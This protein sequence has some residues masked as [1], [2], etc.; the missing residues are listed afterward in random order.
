M[1]VLADQHYELRWWRDPASPNFRRFFDITDLAAVRV[2]V[3]G[4]FEAQ[5]RLLR[6]WVD[7]DVAAEVFDGVRVDHVDGLADPR[8]YLADLRAVVGD[9]RL[10]LVEKI[11]HEDEALPSDW[12]VDGTTGYELADLTTGAVVYGRSVDALDHTLEE[13]TGSPPD[14]PGTV[15]AAKELVLDRLLSAEVDRLTRVFE[16]ALTAADAGGAGELDDRRR[17]VRELLA[18]FD[19]YRTYVTD[20][21]ADGADRVPH[22]RRC[23]TSDGR[24]GSSALRDVLVVMLADPANPE[25]RHVAR[26][27]EQTLPAVTAKAVEDTALYRYTRLVARNDVGVEP[28]RLSWGPDELHAHLVA[29][30]RWPLGLSAGSTHD[31]KRSEDVRARIA[32]AV[33]RAPGTGGAWSPAGPPRWPV[34]PHRRHRRS[35]TWPGRPWSARGRSTPTASR[36]IW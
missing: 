27:F 30:G 26:R 34:V 5:T 14:W 16:R 29:R 11:L 33:A 2:E 24:Y 20:G 1:R 4:V 10:L 6:Q 3:P 35:N 17:A 13:W 19:V 12:P 25:E 22:R 9:D 28:A 8:A 15:V 7:D 31:A 21:A 18:S 36:R 23:V 32:A